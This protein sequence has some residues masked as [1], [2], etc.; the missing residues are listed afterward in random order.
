MNQLFVTAIA[1]KISALDTGKL[2]SERARHADL[3]KF[4]RALS[5]VPGVPPSHAETGWLAGEGWGNGSLPSMSIARAVS[6]A[7]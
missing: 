3:E 5:R 6:K 7:S 4:Q 2:L 1:E